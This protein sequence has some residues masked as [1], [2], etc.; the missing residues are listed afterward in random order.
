MSFKSYVEWLRSVT[1]TKHFFMELLLTTFWLIS[2]PLVFSGV[3]GVSKHPLNRKRSLKQL[4]KLLCSSPSFLL[5]TIHCSLLRSQQ[6]RNSTRPHNSLSRRHQL[7]Q[8]WGENLMPC[9]YPTKRT[10]HS[11]P[12]AVRNHWFHTTTPDAVNKL[13]V[14]SPIQQDSLSILLLPMTLPQTI[15][16]RP[17]PAYLVPITF[18]FLL[19]VYNG[20][21]NCWSGHSW[22]SCLFQ[23]MTDS[24]M[25]LE[26]HS[27]S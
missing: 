19:L 5:N 21:H 7:P 23:G 24:V 10:S 20:V 15:L 3:K 8:D 4:L 1:A 25:Q 22:P 12:D 2:H 26:S 9:K 27:S 16:C 18:P 17:I 11:P 6:K 13:K 14:W